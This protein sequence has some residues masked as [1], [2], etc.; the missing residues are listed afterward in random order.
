SQ[1]QEIRVRGK[2]LSESGE[3]VP[4]VTVRVKGSTKGTIT[5]PDGNYSLLVPDGKAVLVFSLI[6]HAPLEVPVDNRQSL[7]VTMKNGV[8]ALSET[9]VVGYGTQNRAKVVGSVASI[10]GEQIA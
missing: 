6:G 9:V 8:T 2:V 3:E 4:G 5:D 7:N 1:S 10:T